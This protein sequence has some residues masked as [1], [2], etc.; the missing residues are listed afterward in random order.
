MSGARMNMSPQGLKNIP[1][2]TM[3]KDFEFVVGGKSYW[4]NSVLADYLSPKIARLHAAD[5]SLCQF[6]VDCKDESGLFKYVL[7]LSIG[8]SFDLTSDNELFFTEVMKALGNNE[9]LAK[10]EKPLSAENAV[11]LINMKR[12]FELD[13]TEEIEFTAS[14]FYEIELVSL[15]RK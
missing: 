15:V 11:K 7:G 3:A 9:M 1:I 12:N 6:K 5:P 10:Y 2:A 8:N 13:F 14:H 4:W